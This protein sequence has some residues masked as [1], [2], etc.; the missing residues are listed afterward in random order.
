[1][2]QRLSS[3]AGHTYCSSCIDE[4]IGRP[5]AEHG[6]SRCPECRQRF[7]L[8]DIRRLFINSSTRNHNI[9]SPQATSSGVCS[10]V[11][12]QGFV[13]QARFIARRLGRI[14][15]ESPV[16]SIKTAVDVIKHVATI[17]CKEAQVRPHEPLPRTVHLTFSQNF[18]CYRKSCGRPYENFGLAWS[19]TLSN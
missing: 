4:L 1:M 11:E 9:S 17:Q 18:L 15:V 3:S 12:T 19:L 13:R 2:T 10:S 14:K 16:Q 8:D 7:Q 6:I 5:S